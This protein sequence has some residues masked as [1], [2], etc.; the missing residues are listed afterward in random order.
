MICGLAGEAIFNQKIA[1][2]PTIKA[3][4]LDAKTLIRVAC[5]TKI[6]RHRLKLAEP[7]LADEYGIPVRAEDEYNLQ[8]NWEAV[9]AAVILD[10]VYAIDSSLCF[11]GWSLGIDVT[12]NPNQIESKLNK[13]Q[14][15]KP[16][17]SSVGIDKTAVCLIQENQGF[18]DLKTALRQV[19]RGA[20]QITVAA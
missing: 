15:L 1:Q 2:H 13:L 14:Q 12:T 16:L 20:S 6:G 10:R 18:S 19:I 5:S 7:Y 17:W 11:L 4:P 8:F 3:L 9:P